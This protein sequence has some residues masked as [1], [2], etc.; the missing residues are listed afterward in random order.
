[1]TCDL[2][3][4]RLSEFLAGELTSDEADDVRRHLDACPT[5][6]RLFR[7]MQRVTALADALPDEP[8]PRSLAMRILGRVDQELAPDLG[9]A[10]EVLTLDQLARYLQLPR[11]ALDE[12]MDTIPSFEIAGQLRFRRDRVLA[13]I[14]ERETERERSRVDAEL[15]EII[16]GDRH[17]PGT[18]Q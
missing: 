5:C 11:A 17:V 9:H 4:D 10:P 1:M 18:L 12:E 3:S 6:G 13:W 15:R 8:P 7:A 2:C 14:E 16:G